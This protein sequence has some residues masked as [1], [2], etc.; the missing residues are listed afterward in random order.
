MHRTNLMSDDLTSGQSPF[1][2]KTQFDYIMFLSFVVAICL[3]VAITI[4][5]LITIGYYSYRVKQ[6]SSELSSLS[7]RLSENRRVG[8]NISA[9]INSWQQKSK[10]AETRIEFLDKE[11]KTNVAWSGVLEKLN[12]LL[13][14]RLW[15]VKLSLSEELIAIRGNTY[16]NVLITT[17]IS[18]LF[19]SGVFTDVNLSYAKKK[20]SQ[21]VLEGIAEPEIIEFELTCRLIEDK[22]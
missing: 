2:F 6:S 7:Q 5:Q 9:Q 11:L 18:N 16:A 17:F 10:E 8:D 4:F 19:H 13:P 3:F 14:A 15:M 21:Q 20:R 12:D 22:F 1:S